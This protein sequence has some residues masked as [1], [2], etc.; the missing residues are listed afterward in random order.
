MTATNNRGYSLPTINGDYGTWGGEL[1][2]GVITV[3]DANLG[4]SAFTSM[5]PGGTVSLSNSVVQNLMQTLSGTAS[6]L[7]LFP[8]P[9]M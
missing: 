3:I 2:V 7:V 1:N 5:G 4:G 9:G 8:T 6:A